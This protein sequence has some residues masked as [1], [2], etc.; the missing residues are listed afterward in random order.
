VETVN[1]GW[2]RITGEDMGNILEF[3]ESWFPES[4]RPA[5]YGTGKAAELIRQILIDEYQ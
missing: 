5:Y 2:N 1:A 3:H 4:E